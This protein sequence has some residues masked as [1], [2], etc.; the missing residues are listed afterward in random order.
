MCR[1][2]TFNLLFIF[3]GQQRTRCI[4]QTS[5]DLYNTGH[6][7][8]NIRLH[9]NQI[10]YPRA[11][12]APARIRIAPPCARSR[13]RH[14]G[15]NHV[16][17]LFLPPEQA[18]TCS[19]GVIDFL[20]ARAVTRLIPLLLVLLCLATLLLRLTSF[21]PAVV[22][23]DEGLYLVQAREWLHGGW[24]LVHEGPFDMS[25]SVKAYFALKMIG[26][27]P[28]AP[29]MK[30]AREEI[31]RRGGA[32]KSNVFT[33]IMLALFGLFVE[34][35]LHEHNALKNGLA[36]TVNIA[37][38]L[39]FLSSGLLWIIPGLCC[40]LGAITGGYV[41]AR[42]ATRVDPVKLR[43]VIVALGCVM[44]AW[45]IWQAWKSA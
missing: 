22:D 38:S 16:K 18:P 23:T 10:R 7:L 19:N 43:R 32:I 1:Q 34:G 31:L 41:S 8:Q 9:G 28:D 35:T 6:T 17:T 5:S 25:A 4:N 44:T 21:V 40:M 33:R 11:V 3:F 30:K 15:Q 42:L 39:F 29:H 14:I 26:D 37:A 45:F 20:H 36:V 2:K 27:K 12:I 24:P 13:T